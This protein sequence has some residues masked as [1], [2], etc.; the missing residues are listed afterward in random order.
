VFWEP[1]CLF[2]QLRHPQIALWNRRGGRR[3]GEAVSSGF[4]WQLGCFRCRSAK[5]SR[6]DGVRSELL[7]V[8]AGAG[9]WA[10]ALLQG[11]SQKEILVVLV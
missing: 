11:P 1:P 10:A 4:I 7:G 8:L 2:S 9:K 6:R 3:M 5:L